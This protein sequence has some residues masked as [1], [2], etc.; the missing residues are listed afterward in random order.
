M[1]LWKPILAAALIAGVLD[2]IY[3]VIHLGGYYN[4]SAMQIFQSI[5]RGVLGPATTTG[6]WGSAG[7]GLFLEFVLTAIMAA[8]YIVPA[9]KITDLRK[10]WWLLGPCYG[11]VVMVAMYVVV[12][13]L[14]AAHGNSALP[15]GPRG[16]DGRVTD[17]Q[18][19]YGTIFAHMILVGLPIGW[20]ARYL[21]PKNE[22]AD[23]RP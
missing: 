4:L 16:P 7:L 23:A 22:S 17:H 5:A 20:A 6:G 9:E 2:L 3:A 8:V 1:K 19:L 11:I 15:D 21:W 13:P 14:S 12:L 18:I 10:Y